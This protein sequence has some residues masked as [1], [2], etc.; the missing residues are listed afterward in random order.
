MRSPEDKTIQAQA[1]F[2]GDEPFRRNIAGEGGPPIMQS[3]VVRILVGLRNGLTAFLTTDEL[4]KGFHPSD[5]PHRTISE[6][7]LLYD[8]A[9]EGAPM[10]TTVR[11]H[12][13]SK[14]YVD[15]DA[16]TR[17]RGGDPTYRRPKH[18]QGGWISPE[19]QKNVARLER[20]GRL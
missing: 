8:R 2:V 11:K 13:A 1:E 20:L 7:D 5:L 19:E 9:D 14:P 6:A 18:E 4:P 17:A 3:R 15:L 16:K 12:G 10:L